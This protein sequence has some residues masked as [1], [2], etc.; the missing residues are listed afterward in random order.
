MNDPNNAAVPKNRGFSES[1][2]ATV[3]RESTLDLLFMFSSTCNELTLGY[4]KFFC[5]VAVDVTTPAERRTKE[6]NYL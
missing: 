1:F 6:F 3:L 2:V 4:L 5:R